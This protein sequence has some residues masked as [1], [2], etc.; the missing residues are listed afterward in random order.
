MS[1]ISEKAKAEGDL[2]EAEF[3]ELET[4]EEDRAQIQQ[5]EEDRALDPEPVEPDEAALAAQDR[6][7]SSE[8]TRHQKALAKAYGDVWPEHVRCALCDGVGF[9]NPELAMS[10]NNAQWEQLLQVAV[11][12]VTD[13]YV[14]D[15]NYETCP[16]C[17][18]KTKTRSGAQDAEHYLKLCDVCSGNGY[19]QRAPKLPTITPISPNGEAT[20]PSIPVIPS[21]G[22]PSPDDTWGRPAGHSHYGIPPAMV[23]G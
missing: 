23:N 14:Q 1:T 20:G 10:L 3:A 5:N 21:Y 22:A 15:P 19:V 2:A 6:A 9:L 18:G 16:N 11:M 7:L 8:D 13:E 17:Q 12:L 4:D